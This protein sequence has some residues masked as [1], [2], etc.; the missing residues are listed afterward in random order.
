MAKLPRLPLRLTDSSTSRRNGTANRSVHSHVE[1]DAQVA[2]VNGVEDEGHTLRRHPMD[3]A[4]HPI[5]EVI[6]AGNAENYYT[7]HD[8]TGRQS[9]SYAQAA[10]AHEEPNNE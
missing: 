8:A 6:S 9:K 5:E 1:R 10:E 4:A 3:K 7:Q 2:R